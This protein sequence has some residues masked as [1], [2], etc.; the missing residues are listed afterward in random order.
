[1]A[2][3]PL[4]T[5]WQ[6]MREARERSAARVARGRWRGAWLAAARDGKKGGQEQQQHQQRQQL[7]TSLLYL[8]RALSMVMFF[9][10]AVT[11]TA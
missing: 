1:M 10:P 4:P 9:V 5:P 3:E 7:H 11:P 6:G 2:P 8:L